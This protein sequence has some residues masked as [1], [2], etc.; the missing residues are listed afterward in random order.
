MNLSEPRGACPLGPLSG[1]S[2][3]EIR[4]RTV[5]QYPWGDAVPGFL[6]ALKAGYRRFNGGETPALQGCAAIDFMQVRG[7]VW[8][9]EMI[10]ECLEK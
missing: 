8:K 1:L 6:L 10:L 9:R 5:H 7:F 2:V 4:N 3:S